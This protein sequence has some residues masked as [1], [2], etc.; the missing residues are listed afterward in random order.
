MT[1]ETVL[2]DLATVLTAPMASM[3]VTLSVH[4]HEDDALELLAVGPETARLCLTMD[5]LSMGA[6][7]EDQDCGVARMTFRALLQAPRDFQ[8]TRQA[9]E[10]TGGLN[11]NVSLLTLATWVR[12][13]VQRVQYEGRSD[14]DNVHGFRFLSQRRYAP[15]AQRGLRSLEQRYQCIIG[16][17]LPAEHPVTVPAA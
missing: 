3:G 9:Q 13:L 4:G 2:T 12:T 17:D 1:P 6:G 7:A 10:V 5:E 15:D 11:D 8:L 14:F 16:L